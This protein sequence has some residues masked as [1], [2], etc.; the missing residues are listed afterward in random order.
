MKKSIQDISVKGKRCLVRV[1]FNVPQDSEGN[2]TDDTRIVGALPTIKYLVANGAKTIL[3]SHLGRPKGQFN[4]K[5]T[6]AP[7]AVALEKLLGQKVIFVDD[8]VGEKVEKAVAELKE[9]EVML[10]ENTRFYKE[11]EADDKEFCKK[12]AKL[13][14]VFVND[15]F[16][17]AHRA[18]ASTTGVAEFVK[19]SVSG[20]LIKKELDVMGKALTNPD[21]PFVA[22]LGGAKVGDKIGVIRNL[23][24]KADVVIVG[25]GMAYTFQKAKGYEVG[26]SLCEDGCIELAKELMQQ[27][28]EKN[29]Q[30]LLP[31]DNVVAAEFSNDA[32][33]KVVDSDK[34]SADMMGMDIGP[35]TVELFCN[36]IKTAKTV[37]W[38]GP[39]GVFEMSNFANGTKQVAKAIAETDCVSIIGGG[40]SA[41]AIKQLGFAD[42]VTHV[43]TGGGA[44]LEF[45]EGKVLPG[46]DCLDDKE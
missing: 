43:S 6:L 14:D 15:A 40:D 32:V 41:A 7:V 16:G 39:M 35:K 9:G 31:V 34:I 12:L 26:T 20:F 11:E 46:I 18:H 22:V 45:L 42:K 37:V 44:S 13:A 29:V 36:A 8:V 1:D 19:E 3:C 30:L 38:N 2:V 17:T 24:E 4:V 28:K 5:Y 21:R 33:R 23:L 27:A 25:G 10:L